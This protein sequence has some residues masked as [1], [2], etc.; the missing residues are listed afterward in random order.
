[1]I[2]TD[3]LPILRMMWCCM[4]PDVAILRWIAY[5][6]SLNPDVRHISGKDNAV[7]DMLSRGRFGDDIAE[8]DNEEVSENYF[9]LEHIFRVNVI[10][11][12]REEEYEGESLLI[13]KVLQEI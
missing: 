13:G 12:F 5:V 6:K 1:M 11:E 9:A 10:R 7:A 4:I 2:E 3:C 8:S